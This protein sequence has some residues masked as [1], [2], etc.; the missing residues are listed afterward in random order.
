MVR[1]TVLRTKGTE[2]QREVNQLSFPDDAA[3]VADMAEKLNR[4]LTEFWKVGQRRR[5]KKEKGD[6]M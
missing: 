3:L 6:E 4:L 5:L 1:G 2:C